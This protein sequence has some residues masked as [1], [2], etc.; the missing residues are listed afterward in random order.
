GQVRIAAKVP[1]REEF[2]EIV[3]H[4]AVQVKKAG[5]KVVLGTEVSD[6][7]VLSARPDAVI[8]ATGSTP[9]SSELPGADASHVLNIWD[10]IQENAP[11][12]QQVVVVDGGEASWQCY[13]TIEFLL[14]KGKQVSL[15][16]R[17]NSIGVDIPTHSLP[18]LHRRLFSKGLSVY[19]YTD[20][21]VAQT[22]S[23][24]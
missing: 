21:P 11:V 17:L 6:D 3:R 10:V 14:G 7:D 2:G 19:L 18:T 12:G 8:V 24:R 13:S 15:I 1:N 20:E 23:Y 5:A 4:L 16:T 22:P 9:L